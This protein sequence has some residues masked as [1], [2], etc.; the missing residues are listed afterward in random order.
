MIMTGTWYVEGGGDWND[1]DE[2]TAGLASHSRK[3]GS[4]V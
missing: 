4:T 1:R 2:Q 3:L